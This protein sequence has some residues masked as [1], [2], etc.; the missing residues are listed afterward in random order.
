MGLQ[1]GG[2]DVSEGAVPRFSFTPRPALGAWVSLQGS[3]AAQ[4]PEVQR[5]RRFSRAVIWG[6]FRRE[7]LV[8]H[9]KVKASPKLPG[10]GIFWEMIQW[11]GPCK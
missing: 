7:L 8:K 4:G 11:S 6:N 1:K 5:L 2:F 3:L 10:H 9:C